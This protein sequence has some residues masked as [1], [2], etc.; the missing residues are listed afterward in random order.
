VVVYKCG[1]IVRQLSVACK[2]A[3]LVGTVHDCG[4]LLFAC[5]RMLGIVH[6]V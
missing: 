2:Q 1:H 4:Q 6:A 3:V 5:C